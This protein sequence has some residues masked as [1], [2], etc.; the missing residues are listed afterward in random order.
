MATADQVK[1]ILEADARDYQVKVSQAAATFER[2]EGRI[3]KSAIG[4]E[5]ATAGALGLVK[6][7]AVG[8]LASVSIGAFARVISSALDYAASL[9][10]VA[11]QVGVTTR[12]LQV[13][14]Y[15]A[16]QVGI[17]QE[18]MDQGLAKLSKSLGEAA[19][20]AKQDAKVFAALGIDIRDTAGHLKTAGDVMPEIADRLAQ[21]EDPAKRAAV[22]LQLFGRAGQKLDTLLSRGSGAIDELRDAAAKLGYILSEEEIQ[23]ADET[24]DKLAKLKAVLEARIAGVVAENAG[25]ILQLADAFL[26]LANA[27]GQTIGKVQRFHALQVNRS[28]V[29]SGS[30]KAAARS[31]LLATP[32]GRRALFEDNRATRQSLRRARAGNLVPSGGDKAAYSARE[33]ALNSELRE[34]I[35]AANASKAKRAAVKGRTGRKQSG[36]VDEGALG[37]LLAPDGKSAEAI[38]REAERAAK[39]ALRNEAAFTNDLGR[40]RTEYIDSLSRL[41]ANADDQDAFAREA[42]EIER[43]ARNRD[44]DLDDRYSAA[45]KEQLK[46]LNDKIAYNQADLVNRNQNIR[47]QQEALTAGQAD[48]TNRRDI[49][50]AQSSLARTSAE[51]REAELRL[52]DLQFQMERL[53]L[54]AVIA[55]KASADAEKKIAEKRLAILGTLEGSARQGVMR[56]TQGPLAAYLD[57][58]PKG[59]A[60]LNEALENVE[61]NGLRALNDGLADAIANGKSLGSVFKNVANQIIAD[62]IRIA[63]QEATLKIFGNGQSGGGGGGIISSIGSFLSSTFGRATGGNVVGG[64]PYMVGERG[65]ERFVPS[66][67]GRIEPNNSRIGPSGGQTLI[68]QTI[69]I[70]AS[71]S[72]NPAGF[73]QRILSHAARQAVA[74]D[75]QLAK[76]LDAAAPARLARHNVLGT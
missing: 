31:S 68:Q 62:L 43:A 70:D 24:A 1:V 44:I 41:T 46:Q 65:P 14:R 37:S 2:A 32:E 54:E 60:E 20:G 36:E 11:Q 34:I 9:G 45:Q 52:L 29:A 28:L 55:S 10:E 38:A 35:S 72:V 16:T 59:A 42:I 69:H 26:E 40:A 19:L 63:V 67:S 39:E 51:R 58:L 33:E 25:A 74:L 50:S 64:Q 12:D 15:A 17:S 18:E 76:G 71:N 6:G 5:R 53:A 57:S 56:N 73:E 3:R 49:L 47:D 30:E 7:A 27:V 23:K 61:A 21:I 22:E 13:Y 66:S 48:L 4:I 8:L 75:Q